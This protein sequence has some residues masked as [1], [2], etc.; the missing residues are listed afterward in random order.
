MF[1]TSKKLAFPL[2]FTVSVK[3]ESEN[4]LMDIQK[5]LY[6]WR[7]NFQQYGI[8]SDVCHKLLPMTETV[9]ATLDYGPK[10]VVFVVDSTKSGTRCFW[11][12]A[13]LFKI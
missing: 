3:Q 6:C 5:I 4:I 10:N 1:C 2:L 7:T 13:F 8:V 11:S 12:N 9:G